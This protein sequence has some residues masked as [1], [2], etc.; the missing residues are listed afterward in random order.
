MYVDAT[1]GGGGHAEAILQADATVRVVGIDA[2]DDAV[3]EAGERL[4]PYGDRATVVQENFRN[5]AAVLE[6]SGI[7]SVNGILLDLGVSSYQLDRSNKGFSYRFEAPLDMRMGRGAVTTA[8]AL[9]NDVTER[10]LADILFRYG[11]EKNARR[12]AR[13]ICSQRAIEPIRTTIQLA[14]AAGRALPGPHRNKS[15]SRI[16]QAFRIAVNDEMNN[17]RAVLETGTE[18]LMPGGRIV[19]IAYHSLEDRIVKDYFKEA[20]AAEVVD[21]NFPEHRTPKAAALRVVTRKPVLASDS[22]IQSNP[23]AR[24]AKLRAAEKTA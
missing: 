17:L 11:E 8:S 5:L 21:P 9:V 7:R 13:T 23:R 18:A 20:A 19:V 3:R 2:D 16:F 22:E 6:R 4:R 10:E 24:S 1:L 14:Q 12:I 15:L